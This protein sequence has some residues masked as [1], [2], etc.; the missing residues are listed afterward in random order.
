MNSIDKKIIEF[1]DLLEDKTNISGSI[2]KY[3]T[4]IVEQLED[5]HTTLQKTANLKHLLSHI[6]SIRVNSAALEERKERNSNVNLIEV[7]PDSGKNKFVA[8]QRSK[9]SK[10]S[11]KTADDIIAYN[12]PEPI[13]KTKVASKEV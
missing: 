5:T 8:P 3:N 12:L 11:N 9:R 13:P 10:N 1:N 6:L 2:G 4:D 7:P